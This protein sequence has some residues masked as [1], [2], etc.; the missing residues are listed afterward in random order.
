M[1]AL[2]LIHKHKRI[3]VFVTEGQPNSLGCVSSSF[4]RH[5]ARLRSLNSLLRF[6]RRTRAEL[7]AAGIP[8]SVILDSAVAYLIAQVDVCMVGSEA[9]VEVCLSLSACA[10]VPDRK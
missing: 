7:S 6:S 10:I 4:A 5:F 1:E 9:V 2:L 8:C 3:S